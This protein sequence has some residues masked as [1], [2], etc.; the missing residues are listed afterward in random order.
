M[1]RRIPSG[2]TRVGAAGSVRVIN[3]NWSRFR[4]A[5]RSRQLSRETGTALSAVE[6]GRSREYVARAGTRTRYWWGDQVIGSGSG[7]LQ[8]VSGAVV[9]QPADGAGRLVL[10]QRVWSARCARECIGVGGGL[11]GMPATA[12]V[13]EGRKSVEVGQLLQRRRDAAAARGSTH[14]GSCVPAV[15]FTFLRRLPIRLRRFPSRQGVELSPETRTS[16]ALAMDHRLSLTSPTVRPS[17]RRIRLNRWLYRGQVRASC[18]GW[19]PSTTR[20]CSG[21]PAKSASRAPVSLLET[22][23]YSPLP[24]AGDF[25]AVFAGTDLDA[26]AHRR[27][28]PLCS[29]SLR[30]QLQPRGNNALPT[31]ER[32]FEE[33]CALEVRSALERNPDLFRGAGVPGVILAPPT[34][35]GKLTELFH[36]ASVH[37]IPLY[38]LIDECRR[39]SPTTSARPSRRG[40]VSRLHP[41]RRRFYRSFFATVKA[42]TVALVAGGCERLFITGVSPITTRRS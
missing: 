31:L 22:H 13:T 4:A 29:R 42:G 5:V 37:G 33:Y 38:M 25:E 11:H 40:G 17:F 15:R 36:H 34:F 20:C 23:A 27:A 2:S 8:R 1:V 35:G 32:R 30:F 21:H 39:T 6:R 3:V 26:R 24:R 12:A 18:V 10:G 9:E 28:P 14:R 7:E 16:K 19:R 41:R